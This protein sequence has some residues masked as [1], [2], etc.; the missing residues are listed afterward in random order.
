MQEKHMGRTREDNKGVHVLDVRNL[1]DT[2]PTYRLLGLDELCRM[3][4]S[5]V[6]NCGV[7]GSGARHLPDVSPKVYTYKFPVEV[8]T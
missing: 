6:G 8:P 3:L 5:R 4:C 7:Y 2:P 1:V